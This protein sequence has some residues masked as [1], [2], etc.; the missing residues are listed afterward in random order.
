ML[1]T[2]RNMIAIDLG[3]SSIKMLELSGS[4]E[5]KI[6]ALGLKT[7]PEGLIVGG[8]I[9]NPTEVGQIISALA[10]QLGIRLKGRRA[11]I[12]IGGTSVIIRR[13]LLD[14]ASDIVNVDDLVKSDFEQQFQ[15]GIEDLCTNFY[16]DSENKYPDGK[17]PVVTAAT[18]QVTV[19][20][21]IAAIKSSGL[22]IGLIDCSALALVNVL[23]YTY[24]KVP[25]LSVIISV[26]AQSTQLVFTL[27]GQYYYNRD[28]PYGGNHYTEEIARF[29]KID[30]TKADSLKISANSSHGET[31]AELIKIFSEV[32]AQVIFEIGGT[33]DFFFSSNELPPEV[34][35]VQS[36]FITGGGSH[37]LG[38]DA[39]IASKFGVSVSILAPFHKVDSGKFE[40][41]YVLSQGHFYAN[42]VGLALRK[43]EDDLE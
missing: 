19:Q 11:A 12:S 29:L 22:K 37:V 34:S 43:F 25:G 32:N 33:I 40:M 10:K 31:P 1:F 42:A 3:S 26:G 14:D 5:K 17:M 38:L 23:E 30:K 2:N 27:F 7:I 39:A 41:D 24:G 15:L 13:L 16:V 35:S 4:R 8:G 6:V 9:E 20:K 36:F 18:K 28:I 21:H